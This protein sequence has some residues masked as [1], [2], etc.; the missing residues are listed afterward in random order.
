MTTL[1]GVV[2]T[3]AVEA[4]TMAAVEI[5]AETGAVTGE[6]GHTVVLSTPHDLLV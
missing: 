3:D 2:T 4:G 6:H 1:V 5:G